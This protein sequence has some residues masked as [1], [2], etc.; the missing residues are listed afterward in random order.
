MHQHLLAVLRQAAQPYSVLFPHDTRQHRAIVFE[1]EVAVP[2]RS[3]HEV[4]DLALQPHVAQGLLSLQQRLDLA[5]QLGNGECGH[6]VVVASLRRQQGGRN[7]VSALRT[8][9]TRF[10][11]LCYTLDAG[12]SRLASTVGGASNGS[13][14]GSTVISTGVTPQGSASTCTG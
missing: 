4:A 9:E 8:S 10:L 13:T 7:R 1:R 5:N 11:K 3:A 6:R 12:A 2:R 14:L